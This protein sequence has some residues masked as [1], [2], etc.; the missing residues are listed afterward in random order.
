MAWRGT[1]HACAS[2][3]AEAHTTA[4]SQ[5]QLTSVERVFDFADLPSEPHERTEVVP[6]DVSLWHVLMPG[7]A[8]PTL[9]T[10][11]TQHACVVVPGLAVSRS[12]VT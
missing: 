11:F 4:A 12:V 10:S 8:L 6:G 1:P 3:H 5:G 7:A 9:L 2:W